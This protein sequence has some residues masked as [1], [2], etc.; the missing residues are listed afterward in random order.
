MHNGTAK[1]CKLGKQAKRCNNVMLNV[2]SPL[3]IS[4][5]FSK[6]FGPGESHYDY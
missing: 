6:N 3:L 1:V 5:E 4:I 2:L